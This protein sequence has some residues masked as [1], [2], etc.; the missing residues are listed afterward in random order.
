LYST[1]WSDGKN[2]KGWKPLSSKKVIQYRIEREMKKMDTHF[3]MP[4]KQR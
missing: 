2:K 1:K 4:T 3:L